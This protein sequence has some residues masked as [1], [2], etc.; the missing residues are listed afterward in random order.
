ML[1]H[2]NIVRPNSSYRRRAEILLGYTYS[3]L[4][5]SYRPSVL[6]LMLT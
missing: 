4:K 5:T 2:T 3:R 6:L 1:S